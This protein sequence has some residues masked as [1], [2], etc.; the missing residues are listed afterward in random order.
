MPIVVE[1][2]KHVWQGINCI[3]DKTVIFFHSY[4][5]IRRNL[6][7]NGLVWLFGV[8]DLSQ[9]D[10]TCPR[11]Y[12]RTGWCGSPG[13]GI[14]FRVTYLPSELLRMGWCDSPGSG[15]SLRVTY[16]PSE[17]PVNGLV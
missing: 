2:V 8:R 15:I 14:S 16:L 9:G 17:L 1:K 3:S 12:Q 10:L 4:Q 13:P 11:S 6:Q 7:M 5:K